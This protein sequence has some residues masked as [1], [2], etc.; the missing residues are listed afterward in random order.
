MKLLTQSVYLIQMTKNPTIKDT[1]IISCQLNRKSPA[2][3]LL[4]H[5]VKYFI[6]NS[7][8]INLKEAKTIHILK[9]QSIFYSKLLIKHQTSTEQKQITID[10]TR[11]KHLHHQNK[12]KQKKEL[13]PLEHVPFQPHQPL[14]RPPS[15]TPIPPP[16]RRPR[17]EPEAAP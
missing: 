9:E 10:L 12:S 13:I 4:D 8:K 11:I 14:H 3:S 1:S 15:P 6:M 17:P 2:V 5:V 7:R 16:R